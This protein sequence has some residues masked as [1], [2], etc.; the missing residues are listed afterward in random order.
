MAPKILGGGFQETKLSLEMGVRTNLCHDPWPPA[1][2]SGVAVVVVG[3]RLGSETSEEEGVCVW[4]G[5]EE[6]EE[7]SSSGGLGVELQ[8]AR[9]RDPY[10]YSWAKFRFSQRQA[11][12]KSEHSRQLHCRFVAVLDSHRRCHF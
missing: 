1:P 6:G 9:P 4:C 10:M 2:S 11:P 3:G 8:A 7:A 5:K 12:Q